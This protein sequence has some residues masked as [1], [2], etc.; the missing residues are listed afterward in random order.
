MAY[1]VDIILTMQVFVYYKVSHISTFI[2]KNYITNTRRVG[3]YLNAFLLGISN[4]AMKFYNFDIF[5]H[6]MI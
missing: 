4:I 1:H 5:K 6:F 3:T 2:F